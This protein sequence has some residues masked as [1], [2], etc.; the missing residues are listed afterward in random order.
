MSLEGPGDAVPMPKAGLCGH[1][2]TADP[3]RRIPAARST[4]PSSLRVV[5]ARG[6]YVRNRR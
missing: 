2:L 5:L 1:G 6:L 4:K 3:L